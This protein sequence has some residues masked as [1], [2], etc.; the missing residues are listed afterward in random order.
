MFRPQAA[1]G[2]SWQCWRAQVPKGS[3]TKPVAGG[4]QAGNRIN[5]A[6]SDRARGCRIQNGTDRDQCGPRHRP[7]AAAGLTGDQVL[8]VGVT[9]GALGGGGNRTGE[10]GA[11]NAAQAFVVAEEEDFVA[12]VEDFRDDDGAASGKAKLVLAK[13]TLG[14]AASVFKEVRGVELIVAEKFPCGA[15]ETVGAGLDGG[16]ENGSAGAAEFG[17]EVGG[18][19]LEFLNGVDRRK[20][21]EVGAVQEVDGVGVVVDAVEQ[22]VVL[23]GARP[24]AAKAPLAA[25]PRVSACG[26]LTP[27]AS[28]AR[29]VKLRPFS[30]R[31]STL[32]ESTT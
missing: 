8:E 7:C 12:A 2:E 11:L 1:S 19:N 18:L 31:L 14:N 9:A 23:G 6:G 13:C 30:G 10:N 32:R 27:A 22:V 26:V 17:A 3:R 29:N 20:N 28:W 21:D 25:L 24:L 16:V 5:C 4:G 15:V